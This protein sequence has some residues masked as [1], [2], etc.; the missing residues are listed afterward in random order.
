MNQPDTRTLE[1]TELYIEGSLDQDGRDELCRLLAGNP[2]LA[3]F[4]SSQLD[5]SALLADTFSGRDFA[6]ETVDVLY[7]SLGGKFTRVPTGA[8]IRARPWRRILA[9]PVAL[10]ASLLLVG[11]LWWFGNARWPMGPVTARVSAVSGS[12]NLQGRAVRAGAGVRQGD[13]IQTGPAGHVTLRFVGEDTSLELAPGT[14][15]FLSGTRAHHLRRGGLVAAVARSTCSGQAKQAEGK[16][17]TV[18][19]PHATIE[20][21]GTVF[22]VETG[23]DRDAD[24]GRS[25]VSRIEAYEGKVGVRRG[26]DDS[27]VTMTG[28]Q[29]VSVSDSAASPLDVATISGLKEVRRG[30]NG[31]I[32]R[33]FVWDLRNKGPQGLEP[34]EGEWQREKGHFGGM[35]AGNKA[36]I[37]LK[38]PVRLIGKPCK[39]SVQAHFA[40]RRVDP[41]TFSVIPGGPRKDHGFRQWF[42]KTYM[43]WRHGTDVWINGLRSLTTV[44]VDHVRGLSTQHVREHLLPPSAVYLNARNTVIESIHIEEI[45]VARLPAPLRSDQAWEALKRK[46]PSYYESKGEGSQTGLIQNML[47]NH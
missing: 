2:T 30:P 1:L 11:G 20:V 41:S 27:R 32:L 15:L 12:V 24:A 38:L 28:G 45:P 8:H 16:P 22:G 3:R 29:H 19:T 6:E 42:A 46:M 7:D 31:E 40:G 4:F 39:V 23:L 26:A 18:T 13:R 17:F 36:P 33:C 35:R 9:L 10:A 34:Q 37:C 47:H 44:R 21:I 5:L 14:D 25:D 43:G